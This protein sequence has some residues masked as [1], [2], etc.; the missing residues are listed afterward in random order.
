MFSIIKAGMATAKHELSVISNN[1]ANSNTTGFKKSMASY[2]DLAPSSLSDSIAA[3]SSGLGSLIEETRISH[4]QSSLIQ[5]EKKT[6]FGLSGNGFF[7]LRNPSD[8]S[9]SFT[10]DGRF[11]LDENGFLRST[12]NCYVLGQP[13]VEGEFSVEDMNVEGLL[14]I[15]IP[16]TKDSEQ[17]TELN[18]EENGRISVVYGDQ[19]YNKIS[20]LALGLFTNPDELREL[21]NSR[22]AATEDAGALQLGRPLSAGFANLKSGWLEAS[23]VDITDELTAMIK[24]QQQFNGAARLMQTNSELLEKLTR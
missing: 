24:A 8:A 3:S 5:T 12:D 16:T 2:A 15:Q 4:S 14:P 13:T 23:N 7:V 22:Y 17:M 20:T 21:G 9:I 1:V 18:V 10:R 6:D 11:G 19:E